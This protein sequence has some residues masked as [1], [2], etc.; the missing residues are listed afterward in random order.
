MTVKIG[1]REYSEWAIVAVSMVLGLAFSAFLVY[2]L[3]HILR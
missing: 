2:G 3:P 1:N